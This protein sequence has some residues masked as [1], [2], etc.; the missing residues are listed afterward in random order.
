[1]E[2]PGKH[3]CVVNWEHLVAPVHEVFNFIIQKNFFCIHG[4]VV[5]ME[6]KWALFRASVVEVAAVVKR[7]SVPVVAA[8]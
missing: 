1:M 7:L 3:K 5:D 2:R 4:E 8:S 6:S